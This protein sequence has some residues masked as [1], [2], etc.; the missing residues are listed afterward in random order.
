MTIY[1]IRIVLLIPLG[2]E[3]FKS[4][5]RER[6]SLLSRVLATKFPTQINA[7][8][9]F[10]DSN[11]TCIRPRYKKNC[12]Q[13][14]SVYETER[15]LYHWRTVA[16]AE[17]TTSALG[18]PSL[19]RLRQQLFLLLSATITLLFSPSTGNGLEC[20]SVVIKETII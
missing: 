1:P 9:F 2:S 18:T 15:N 16:Q 12:P 7:S 6:H 19:V 4:K 10:I 17:C 14:A 13:L 11:K 20:L 8:R 3:E 5:N